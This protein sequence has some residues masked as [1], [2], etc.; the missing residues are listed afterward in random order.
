VNLSGLVVLRAAVEALDEY[1][2]QER[3]GALSEEEGKAAWRAAGEV[4]RAADHIC[5]RLRQAMVA[6]IVD[7]ERER[8]TT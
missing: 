1:L 2:N 8:R 5:A 3:L 7:G 4:C 6:R